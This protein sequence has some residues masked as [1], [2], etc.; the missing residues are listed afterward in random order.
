MGIE[1]GDAARVITLNTVTYVVGLLASAGLAFALQPV[2]VPAFF[3]S[4]DTARPL[5]FV[6]SPS[7]PD[8]SSGAAAKATT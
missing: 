8:I 3:V 4:A 7:S 1:R 6:A 5:G 2:L